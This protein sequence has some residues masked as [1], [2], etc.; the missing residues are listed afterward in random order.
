[1]LL[2]EDGA[3]CAPADDDA[4]R[5][6]ALL[7]PD[8]ALACRGAL[9]DEAVLV[10][11]GESGSQLLLGP[12]WHGR[13]DGRWAFP[14]FVAPAVAGDGRGAVPLDHWTEPGETP[15]LPCRSTTARAA[16]LVPVPPAAR[17]RPQD[18]ELWLQL[19]VLP[20]AA[21][22]PLR[23]ALDGAALEPV[24]ARGA[25][26]VARPLPHAPRAD[27]VALRLDAPTHRPGRD[28]GSADRRELGVLVRSVAILPRGGG[29]VAGLQAL[30]DGQHAL[31][32]RGTVV[33]GRTRAARPAARRAAGLP[34]HR[35]GRRA[36]GAQPAPRVRRAAADHRHVAA[37]DTPA[38]RLQFAAPVVDARPAADALRGLSPRT[39]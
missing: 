2:D 11:P 30:L 36:A 33:P 32:A 12:G 37:C 1:M 6:A 21:P 8:D 35:A 27:L 4:A 29:R 20:A 24:S 18:F 7:A 5:L 13:E 23:L 10:L 38:H 22:E 26:L 9:P 34:R 28:G 16:L 3:P 25:Q 31:R 19:C 17:R 15:P 14:D 39:A